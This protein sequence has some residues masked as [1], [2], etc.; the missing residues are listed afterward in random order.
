LW[1]TKRARAMKRVMVLATR[2]EC[3]KESDGFSGKSNGDKGGRQATATR[4]MATVMSMMW[5]MATGTRL[6]GDKVGK[7]EGGNGDGDGNS[8]E[9]SG[10]IRGQWR[11]RQEQ[12]QR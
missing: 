9:G 6:A 2:V 3:N 5:A 7:G 11:W 10:Q 4:A 12:W 8:N 1:A